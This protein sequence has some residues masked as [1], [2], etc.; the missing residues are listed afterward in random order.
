MVALGA[1][2]RAHCM[3]DAASAACCAKKTCRL[4][5][6]HGVRADRS[7][8]WLASVRRH[9]GSYRSGSCVQIF[10]SRLNR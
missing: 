1:C 7:R 4:N 8:S 2:K 9:R 10:C 5:S 6:P 3:R